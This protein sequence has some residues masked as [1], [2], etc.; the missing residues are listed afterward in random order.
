[1]PRVKWM[2]RIFGIWSTTMTS[3]IPALKPTSTGSEIKFATIPRRG[4]CASN[5]AA[6]TST[7]NVRPPGA[8]SLAEAIISVAQDAS[9]RERVV[10]HGRE[11]VF[12][13]FSAA[14]IGELLSRMYQAITQT[15]R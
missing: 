6:P 3:P 13:N 7:V 2:P 11:V 1:V 10:T 14:A 15:E 12:A 8:A 5:S 9:L 4:R